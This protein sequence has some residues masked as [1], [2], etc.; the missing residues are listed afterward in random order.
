M[1]SPQMRLPIPVYSN[2][3]KEGGGGADIYCQFLAPPPRPQ[4]LILID[5]SVFIGVPRRCGMT[6]FGMLMKCSSQNIPF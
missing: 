5:S 6:S 3:Y 2:H 1:R 4:A